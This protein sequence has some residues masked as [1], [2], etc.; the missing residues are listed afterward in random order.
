MSSSQAVMVEPNVGTPFMLPGMSSPEV[1][2]LQLQIEAG[3]RVVRFDQECVLIPELNAKKQR[4]PIVMTKSYSLPLWKKK[5]AHQPM[6]DSEADSEE[7]AQ[8]PRGQQRSP[9]PQE[10]RLII[11]VP[12]PTY[13]FRILRR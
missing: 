3:E 4:S 12:I 1:E 13:V 8:S 2:D 10:E 6:S 5:G 11:K 9:S 7:T